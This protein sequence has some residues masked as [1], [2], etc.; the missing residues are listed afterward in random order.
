MWA[1]LHS[2]VCNFVSGNFKTK[3]L[4]FLDRLLKFAG[5]NGNMDIGWQQ[6]QTGK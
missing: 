2:N 4:G 5:N 1:T 3:L 6:E